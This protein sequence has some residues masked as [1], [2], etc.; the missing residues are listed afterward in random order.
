MSKLILGTAQ[1]GKRYGI[2]NTT[3]QIS[4]NEAKKILNLAKNSKIDLI[5]TAIVYGKSEEIIGDIGIKGFN[6]VSKLPDIPSDCKNINLWVQETIKLSLLKL[7]IPSLY[8]LLVHKSNNLYGDKGKKL[9]DALNKLKLDGLVKKIGI[10]IYDPL[11]C[12]Q[13]MQKTRIDIVQAPLNIIDRRL[14]LTGWLSRLHSEH[15]EVHTRS[16]FLQ[17][18]LQMPRNKIPKKFDRWS[19]V[20]DEWSSKLKV[21]NLTATEACLFYPL[22]LSEVDRVI[23]GVDNSN[24]LEEIIKKSKLKKPRIDLSF[25]ISNDEMLINPNNWYS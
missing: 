23:V 4:F 1:F 13:I 20:F 14:E 9:I 18:L 2:A 21:N 7:R 8:A 17:G 3:G 22:S 16:V 5:D 25:M 10:S 15:I 24:Q 12:E 19:K 11:E 6:I